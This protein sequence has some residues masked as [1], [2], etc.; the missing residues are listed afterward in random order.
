MTL[1]NAA[2]LSRREFCEGDEGLMVSRYVSATRTVTELISNAHTYATSGCLEMLEATTH[3]LSELS[4]SECVVVVHLETKKKEVTRLTGNEPKH[5]LAFV[6]KFRLKLCMN[7]SR[8]C[9]SLP[10]NLVA[11]LW[12]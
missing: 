3:K 2:I 4:T 10:S 1:T 6:P 5:N 12:W 8:V 7:V 9:R 11:L